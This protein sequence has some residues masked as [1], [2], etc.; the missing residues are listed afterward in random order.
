[1]MEAYIIRGGGGG[2][3]G[4]NGKIVIELWINSSPLSTA[5][6][7]HSIGSAPSNYKNQCGLLSIGPLGTNLCEFF[8]Q[9][10]MR[11]LFVVVEK[12]RS[13]G[14]RHVLQAFYAFVL[15]THSLL[16]N[17]VI[18]HFMIYYVSVSL[19]PIDLVVIWYF[20]Q[21]LLHR[22]F[23]FKDRASSSLCR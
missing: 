22:N 7:R 15:G 18:V 1:M 8:V 10:E 6:M 23:L 21:C 9:G 19:W 4:G 11:L 14:W 5:Y 12:G 20:L 16:R 13:C 3:G 17:Q 2:G